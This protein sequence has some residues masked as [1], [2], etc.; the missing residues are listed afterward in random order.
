MKVLQILSVLLLAFV[1]A[2]CGGGGGSDALPTTANVLAS[3]DWAARTRG[4]KAPSSAQSVV[5]TLKDALPGGGDFHF[6]INRDAAP[7]AYT[8][9]YTSPGLAKL[10]T[11]TMSAMFYGQNDGSGDVVGTAGASVE[12][13]ADGTGIPELETFGSFNLV[14][15]PT[16]QTVPLGGSKDLRISAFSE[17][18]TTPFKQVAIVP[19]SVIWKVILGNDKLT[20]V[21]GMAKGLLPGEA[22]LTA[23]VDGIVSQ[24]EVVT[25]VSNAVITIAPKTVSLQIG[26]PQVFTTSLSNAPDNTVTW[27]LKNLDFHAGQSLEE[28]SNGTISETGNYVAPIQTGIYQLTATSKYD[29]SK[30]A[31][32]VITV[33]SPV[34][35]LKLQTND[36]VFD[37]TSN[38]ILASVSG[39]AGTNANSIAIINPQTAAIEAYIPVGSEP[40]KLALADDGKTLYISLNGIKSIGRFD[41]PS[42][43][44]ATTFRVDPDLTNSQFGILG[45]TVAPKNPEVIAV[46]YYTGRIEQGVKVFKSG[47]F[48]QNSYLYFSEPPQIT[49]G[50]TIDQ[51]FAFKACILS[52]LGFSE[53]GLKVLDSRYIADFYTQYTDYNSCIQFLDGRLYTS[54]YSVLD[55]ESLTRISNRVIGGSDAS[56]FFSVSLPNKKGIDLN[57]F[58][59]L[60]VF[61]LNGIGNA[62]SMNINALFTEIAAYRFDAPKATVYSGGKILTVRNK[63]NV[64]IINP[65]PGL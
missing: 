7:A 50:G 34:S 51:I 45:M 14:K 29:P 11:W 27:S 61:S 58:G 47:E 44:M 4:L 48:V 8:Q 36:M 38:R 49:F 41:I 2:G 35:I 9:T 53:T 24:P 56:F 62:A 28:G 40:D 26:A 22:T 39:K 20:I 12:I 59:N 19:G 46:S 25:V 15:I 31:S 23:T 5:I 10:G 17:D 3:I 13:K 42:R 30:T 57:D 16:F 64:F 33:V 52:K 32:S 65:T 18:Q 60:R 55:P 21:N 6:L 1:I 54:K 37:T 43:T 63:E